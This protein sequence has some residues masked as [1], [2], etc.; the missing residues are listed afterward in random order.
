MS[1]RNSNMFSCFIS[2]SKLLVRLKGN[3]T[4]AA[5]CTCLVVATSAVHTAEIT[6]VL[7]HHSWVWSPIQ[8]TWCFQP[9]KVSAA[10][11]FIFVTLTFSPSLILPQTHFLVS[12]TE[13]DKQRQ[14]KKQT[15][16]H[17]HRSSYNQSGAKTV[18][19]IIFIQ[20]YLHFQFKILHVES[21]EQPKDATAELTSPLICRSWWA[22]VNNPLHQGPLGP[23]VCFPIT[24]EI[25]ECSDDIRLTSVSGM[26]DVWLDVSCQ[27]WHRAVQRCLIK[28][29][30]SPRVQSLTPFTVAINASEMPPNIGCLTCLFVC[31]C[32]CVCVCVSVYRLA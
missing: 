7:L 10:V 30:L 22:T 16:K 27:I 5:A 1:S 24:S 17:P 29:Q 6:N 31:V 3:Y 28:M 11:L 4:K 26:F 32:V 20:Q 13:H 25:C 12:I 14:E 2:S 15:V 19:N 9:I 21:L 23:A 18:K 8:Q